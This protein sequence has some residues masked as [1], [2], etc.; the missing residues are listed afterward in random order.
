MFLSWMIERSL[1]SSAFS[2]NFTVE[3]KRQQ[4]FFYLK[5]IRM[6][7]RF[8]TLFSNENTKDWVWNTFLCMRVNEKLYVWAVKIERLLCSY[9]FYYKKQLLIL[10]VV[11]SFYIDFC[12]NFY[13][14]N[15]LLIVF[16]LMTF[17][18]QKKNSLNFRRTTTKKNQK[19]LNA[20]F[21]IIPY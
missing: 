19:I 18:V 6:L 20:S 5:Q 2:K 12:F 14:G 3:S 21:N 9:N 15:K 16:G 4:K 8:I 10:S 13:M 1:W 11:G 17:Q 7:K